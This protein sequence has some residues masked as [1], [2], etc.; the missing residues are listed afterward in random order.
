MAI[1]NFTINNQVAPVSIIVN[2]E[3]YAKCAESPSVFELMYHY[4]VVETNYAAAKTKMN[5]VLIPQLRS[6]LSEYGLS[7]AFPVPYIYQSGISALLSPYGI[8]VPYHITGDA[9]TAYQVLNG[10]GV[11]A[12]TVTTTVH[13]TT[14]ASTSCSSSMFPQ[15]FGNFRDTDSEEARCVVMSSDPTVT[16]A[17]MLDIFAY[18]DQDSQ[19]RW[20]TTVVAYL[21]SYITVPAGLLDGMEPIQEDDPLAQG[22]EPET[23]GYDVGSPFTGV[24]GLGMFSRTPGSVGFPS[25]PAISATQTGL[26]T[27]YVGSASHMHALADFLW[28]NLFDLDTFK[29]LFNDPMECIIGASILPCTPTHNDAATIIFGNVDTEISMPKATDQF[30][31]VDCGS[32]NVTEYFGAYLDYSPY[33]KAHIF[34]PYIGY[35]ELNV[36]EI[37]GKSLAVKYLVDCLSGA[38][39]V[40]V[41][42]GGNVLYQYSGSCATPIP[43]TANNWGQVLTSIV[44]VAGQ[45]VGGAAAGPA[46][47]LIAGG[48]ALADSAISGGFKPDIIR[49]GSVTGSGGALGV[50]VPYLILEWP[51]QSKVPFYPQFEGYPT[52]D[53]LLL[54]QCRG[55]TKVEEINLEGI[56]CT[57]AEL[58]EIENL[59]KG[60]VLI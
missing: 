8:S 25:A 11:S 57:S 45:A 18:L 6:K 46:G 5:T 56:P 43:L 40:C 14:S 33:T 3:L 28:S 4:H 50:Q 12:G 9:G 22:G 30:K 2:D 42:A 34:L 17:Y 58:A 55:Y 37:M 1:Y 24:G 53:T 36:D 16:R 39:T 15:V 23:S 51:N 59:L 60:G 13:S 29:K 10:S 35:K 32:I 52:N 41:A 20:R 27:L 47:A 38:I 44:E 54:S 49:A 26:V 7:S 19:N 48:S 31:Q 21:P